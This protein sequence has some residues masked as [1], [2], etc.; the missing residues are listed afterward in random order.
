MSVCY[1][2]ARWSYGGDA[3]HAERATVMPLIKTALYKN[4]V[5]PDEPR[6]FCGSDAGTENRDSVN[7][8]LGW[9]AMLNNKR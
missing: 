3:V 8:A 7:E 2:F 4:H 9:P 1:G 5:C 6:L